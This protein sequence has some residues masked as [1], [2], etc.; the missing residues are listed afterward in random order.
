[1]FASV[2]QDKNFNFYNGETPA[3]HNKQ[4]SQL[5]QFFFYLLNFEKE[6]CTT[7]I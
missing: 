6:L 7:S 1:M 4:C 2:T 3:D 5:K